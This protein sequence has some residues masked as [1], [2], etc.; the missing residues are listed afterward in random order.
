MGVIGKVKDKLS[1]AGVDEAVEA[2]QAL[3]KQPGEG[4]NVPE[5]VAAFHAAFEKLLAEAKIRQLVVLIDDLD[6]CLPDTAIDT[7]EAV[8]L[9]LFTKSTAFVVAADEAMIEYAVR[10]HFPD[11]PE[12]S[13]PRTYAR[14]YLEKLVQVP[15]RIPALGEMETRMYVS[16]L[17]IGAEVG[18][19]SPGYRALVAE[20]KARMR[21]PW[22]GK[23]LDPTVLKAQLGSDS[24]FPAEALLLSERIGPVLAATTSG[25]PRQIKR[26]INSLLLR[27]RTAKARGFAADV[28]IQVL[29]KLML[30][31]RNFPDWFDR[32]AALAA[33][34]QQGTSEEIAGL[35]AYVTA[36][37]L[38][39]AGETNSSGLAVK[40]SEKG[41]GV[42]K[43]KLRDD[44]ETHS[45]ENST[46]VMA[47]TPLQ[48]WAG[49]EP[50]IREVDLRPY[51][52][53]VKD[54]KNFFGPISA[55]GHLI[56]LVDKLC[57]PP[58]VV[59][60]YSK[61]LKALTTVEA[62]QVFE[63]LRSRIVEAGQLKLQP[64]G[65]DGM[66]VLVKAHPLLEQ[67]IVDFIGSL[68]PENLGPWAITGWS[69]VIKSPECKSAILVTMKKWSEV[70][71]N[72]ILALAAKAALKSFDKG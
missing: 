16:L 53:V 47:L 27:M 12:S 33:R 62:E 3:F 25:N 28:N 4:K 8:R 24:G 45:D 34:S 9:F 52:F 21:R 30:A 2:T 41:G 70:D 63:L 65:I 23:Y 14:N 48:E 51:L 39:D 42:A 15:F 11:L 49:V 7:L 1:G 46:E 66:Q 71:N 13:G 55:L 58:L 22:Q 59:Q 44:K 36:R 68:P 40:V 20:A 35:E 43:K 69:S 56:P 19:S 60:G 54:R 18:A 50:A 67:K 37:K 72:S 17:L 31:E 29:A 6:R 64:K 61:E 10:K 5:E 26:F 32:M 38:V 57:G